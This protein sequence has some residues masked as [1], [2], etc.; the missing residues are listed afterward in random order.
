VTAT[1]WKIQANL[2]GRYV[3]KIMSTAE[4][5]DTVNNV[6]G[7]YDPFFVLNSKVTFSPVKYMDLSVAWDNMLNRQYYYYYRTPGRMWWTQ[8]TLKY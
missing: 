3:S 7:S 6:F 5:S 4:N 8:L 1:Y 2:S